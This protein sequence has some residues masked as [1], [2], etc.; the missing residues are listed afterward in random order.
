MRIAIMPARGG[1]KRIERKNIAAFCGRPLL[2]FPLAAARA[3]GLFDLIHV[4]TEDETIAAVAA[5][6]GF[7]PD[8]LRDPALAD[9]H[10]PLL[11][12]L[13]WVLERYAERGRSFDTVCLLMPTAPLI[14]ADDLAA[15]C[16]QFESAAGRAPVL[17]VTPMPCPVEWAMRLEADGSLVAIE[18]EMAEIRSQDLAKAYIDSGTFIFFTAAQ[19]LSYPTWRPDYRAYVLPRYKAVDIDDREDFEMAERLYRGRPV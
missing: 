16:A 4:S 2:T 10:T 13:R 7:P 6:H 18:P 8:F 12:V 11:P 1:S 9:D 17:A 14:E 3:S 5:Q 19:L 15:A